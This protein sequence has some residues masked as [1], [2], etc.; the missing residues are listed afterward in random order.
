MRKK[1]IKVQLDP[2]VEARLNDLGFWYNYTTT[3]LIRACIDLALPKLEQFLDQQN[4]QRLA[5]RKL[6]ESGS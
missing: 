2:Q 6:S 1:R 4:T 5:R 3:A